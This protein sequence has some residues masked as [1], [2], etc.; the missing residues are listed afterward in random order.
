MMGKGCLESY[1]FKTLEDSDVGQFQG[2]NWVAQVPKKTAI[3]AQKTGFS[4][5]SPIILV[6]FD[7]SLSLRWA[8]Q[9]PLLVT[10]VAHFVVLIAHVEHF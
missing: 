2:Q 1:G 3:L 10:M 6:L 4:S 5:I 9:W 8:R 7:I